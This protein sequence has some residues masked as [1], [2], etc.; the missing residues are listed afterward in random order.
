MLKEFNEG[1][2]KSYFCIAA[3]IIEV[4]AE[5][6][7]R[8]LRSKKNISAKPNSELLELMFCESEIINFVIM[9]Y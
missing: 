8:C 4:I 2:S 7:G 1:R 6:S 3:T 9:Y 5:I